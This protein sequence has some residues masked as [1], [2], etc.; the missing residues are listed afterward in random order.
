M[1][2]S[3]LSVAQTTNTQMRLHQPFD[4]NFAVHLHRAGGVAR[5]EADR[6]G[7]TEGVEKI[8]NI[9]SADPAIY[10]IYNVLREFQPTIFC[11]IS[12]VQIAFPL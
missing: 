10:Y 8:R 7:G 3:G 11:T 6:V 9:T 5:G 4:Y 12:F 1:K 2:F